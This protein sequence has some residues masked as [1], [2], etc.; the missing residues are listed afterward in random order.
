MLPAGETFHFGVIQHFRWFC[1]DA[2]AGS[3]PKRCWVE[4]WVRSV[5]G[6]DL[7]SIQD[8]G[9]HGRARPAAG[10]SRA[11]ADRLSLTR[12]Q[13]IRMI[14]EQ[15]ALNALATWV[16]A[17]GIHQVRT[18]LAF[19]NQAAQQADIDSDGLAAVLLEEGERLRNEPTPSGVTT[20]QLA[21]VPNPEQDPDE[22]KP[23][24]TQSLQAK[25]AKPDKKNP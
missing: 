11:L 22:V 15:F 18:A 14:E 17:N 5:I 4:S 2:A 24:Q 9:W 8:L 16:H 25:E 23:P 10:G 13:L 21:P 6:L 12:H 3:Q 1:N 7:S 19:A 20:D